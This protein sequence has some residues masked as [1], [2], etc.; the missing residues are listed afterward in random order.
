MRDQVR[1]RRETVAFQVVRDGVRPHPAAV[2]P[3]PGRNH[4]LPALRQHVLHGARCV[5]HQ[6]S[7]AQIRQHPLPV[8]P[9]Q[10]R[11]SGRKNGPPSESAPS[12]ARASR[13]ARAPSAPTPASR[14]SSAASWYGGSSRPLVED[15]DPRRVL[16]GLR[17]RVLRLGGQLGDVRVA[18][19]PR[20]DRRAARPHRR[21]AGDARQSAV[22]PPTRSPAS[23]AA[24]S[25]ASC[26]PSPV[27]AVRDRRQ[28]VDALDVS[29][30]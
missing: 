23:T 7:P 12:N 17:E 27:N 14:S 16:T 19:P 24:A 1:V 8:R 18:H 25:R 21:R 29:R 11:W 9:V 5:Q 22:R 26:S 30:R 10:P 4:G 2:G 20:P 3:E 28:V 13:T 15:L 6:L